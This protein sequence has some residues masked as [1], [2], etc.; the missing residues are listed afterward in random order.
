MVDEAEPIRAPV[1]LSDG[2]DVFLCWNLGEFN[3]TSHGV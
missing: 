2:V 1:R 3:T